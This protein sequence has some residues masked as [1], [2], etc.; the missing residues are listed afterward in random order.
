LTVDY[1]AEAAAEM[2]DASARGDW[3]PLPLEAPLLQLDTTHDPPLAPFLDEVVAAVQGL[4]R[5]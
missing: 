4:T 2:R 5:V 3:A 1:D